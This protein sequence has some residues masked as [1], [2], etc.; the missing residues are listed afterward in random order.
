LTAEPLQQINLG[1]DDAPCAVRLVEAGTYLLIGRIHFGGDFHAADVLVYGMYDQQI[2]LEIGD[3]SLIKV[4]AADSEWEQEFV[5]VHTINS[6]R[7][8]YLYA[9]N[10]TAERGGVIGGRTGI[11]WVRLN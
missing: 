1:P 10:N 2:E 5:R 3:T 9:S 7:T 6:P 11:T 4:P 8:I